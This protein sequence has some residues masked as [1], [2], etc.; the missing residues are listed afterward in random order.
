MDIK[1]FLKF[2][3]VVEKFLPNLP[4]ETGV[5]IE[6]EKPGAEPTP[7]PP[8]ASADGEEP[9]KTESETLEALAKRLD[10]MSLR[11]IVVLRKKPLRDIEVLKEV[12]R[13]IEE[14]LEIVQDGKGERK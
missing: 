12:K 4:P 11:D 8:L 14:I 6:I 10:D 5:S 7:L 2:D 3:E 9:V 13:E 1:L